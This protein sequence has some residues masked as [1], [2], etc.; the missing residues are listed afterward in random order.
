MDEPFSK[1][2]KNTDIYLVNS[3]GKTKSFYNTCK[4]V[5]LG[6][7]L[8]K[9]GG[10]NPLEAARFGCN[11]L[12]GKNISNFREIYKFLDKN[13]ISHM[14]KSRVEFEKK[15]DFLLS[16]KQNSSKNISYRIS[17]IGKKILIKTQK[18]INFFI[19]NAT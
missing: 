1:I 10:Q 6:G 11:I 12:H 3:Y 2:D 9:R 14:V 5:F 8:I 18:E 19:G 13:K 4:N 17:K 16:K 15:L 7:S